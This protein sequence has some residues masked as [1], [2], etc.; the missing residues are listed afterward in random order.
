MNKPLEREFPLEIALSFLTNDLSQLGLAVVTKTVGQFVQSTKCTLLGDDSVAVDFG[1]GKGTEESCRTG[2]TFEAA[3][4]YF[5]QPQHIDPSTLEYLKASDFLRT[6][7][8]KV[9]RA[10]E[11]LA[12]ASDAPLPFRRYQGLTTAL[13]VL[14]PLALACPKYIDMLLDEPSSFRHDKFDY[15]SLQ[16][17]S[18]NSGVAIGA[19]EEE[20][21]IHGILE[22]I[23]RDTL[24]RF[25]VSTFIFPEQSKIRVVKTS[26]MP[27][28]MQRVFKDVSREVGGNVILVEMQSN[29]GVPVFLSSL[30]DSPFPID[31]TG[32]GASLSRDHAALRSLY[33]LV[34]CFHVTTEF[35]PESVQVRDNQVLENLSRH[36]FHLRCAKMKFGEHCRKY[37]FESV[38]F[39]AIPNHDCD[40]TVPEYLEKLLRILARSGVNAYSTNI[41]S[42]PSGINVTHSF[43]DGQ[44]NFFCVT[45]GALVFPN[46]MPTVCI[47]P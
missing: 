6:T 39:D 1:Y 4:H 7:P 34:Q 14:Y 18:T 23:E 46:E 40:G 44:D 43:I 10:L 20:A 30:T 36:S 33:E 22:A 37:G 12:G 16:R 19:T 13:E 47:T 17:Y 26:T 32:F 8:L 27:E 2:A 29:L 5:S 35:H 3:E 45:E 9:T 25:L 24:S 38:A 42:L 28:Y 15:R 21:I 41:A 11:A 31:V